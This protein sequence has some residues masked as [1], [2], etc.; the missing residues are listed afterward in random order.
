M[1]K[2]IIQRYYA[3][4]VAIL[5]MNDVKFITW[6]YSDDLLPGNLKE[7]IQSKPTA[8]D[9]ADHFLHHG[10]KN[11]IE[12]FN[13]LLARMESYSDHLRKFADKIHS[14]IKGNG[15]HLLLF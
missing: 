10:I 15:F 7:E 5:P 9:K 13:K 6:L 11:D 14:E 1:A 12:S 4:L 8:A 3:D 2:D